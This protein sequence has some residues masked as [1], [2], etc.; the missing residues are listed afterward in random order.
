LMLSFVS[1]T[2]GSWTPAPGGGVTRPTGVVLA[3][4]RSRASRAARSAD[5]SSPAPASA[6]LVSPASDTTLI[7]PP[8]G[9]GAV[10]LNVTWSLISCPGLSFTGAAG[11]AVTWNGDPGTVMLFTSSSDPVLVRVTS[12]VASEPTVAARD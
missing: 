6:I 10:G 9:P 11:T 8:A 2:R 3:A 12:P 4:A 5:D 7:W 1:T